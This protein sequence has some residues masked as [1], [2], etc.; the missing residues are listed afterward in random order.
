MALGATIHAFDIEL[1]DVDRGVYTTLNL[2]V[3]QHP[4]EAPDFL[5]TRVLAYCLEYAEGIGF[6]AGLSNPDEPAIF[7]RDLTGALQVWV[8][9]GLPEPDRL[10]RASKAAPRVA[11]YTHR[12]P[13][14]WL[15]RLAEAKIHRAEKLDVVAFDRAWIAGIVARLD[16]RM[17]M[18]L[19]RSESE[20]YL[21]I[22]GD[23]LHTVPDRPLSQS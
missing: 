10:H 3:A 16:R 23:T 8:D 2:R 18:S 13:S 17:Q 20:I 11:V 22:G 9:I 14:Q 19:A 7:V 4:S 1:S 5:V 6:S 15:T 12:D 21:S